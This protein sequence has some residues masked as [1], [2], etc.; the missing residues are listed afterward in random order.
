LASALLVFSSY[1]VSVGSRNRELA[2]QRDV[3]SAM[4]ADVTGSDVGTVLSAL[5]PVADGHETA[6]VRISAAAHAY[7]TTLAVDPATFGKVALFPGGKPALVPW[8]RLQLAT[9]PHLTITGPTIAML[10]TPHGLS[11]SQGGVAFQ[12]DLINDR[13]APASVS[14][15]TMPVAGPR[16]LTAPVPCARGC[17]VV[18]LHRGVL[19]GCGVQRDARDQPGGGGGGLDTCQG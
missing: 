19:L 6:V 14:L 5:A 4:V 15:G 17:T 9:G 2:A 12:L 1:A 10:L 13:G 3:G 8:S 11:V 7:R 18:G 16:T